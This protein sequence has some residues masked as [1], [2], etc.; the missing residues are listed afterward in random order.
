MDLC[1]EEKRG[2]GGADRVSALKK[3]SE[4][5][6]SAVDQSTRVS[7]MPH[8]PHR[9]RR[10]TA[11]RRQYQYFDN[12]NDLADTLVASHSLRST[13]L[14]SPHNTQHTL[15]RMPQCL[16]PLEIESNQIRPTK[17]I[18]KSTYYPLPDTRVSF[19]HPTYF[20]LQAYTHGE[21]IR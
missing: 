16:L 12:K 19:Q 5:A 9:R 14:R 18:L 4:K 17:C 11:A 13:H 2:E 10:R 7:M 20:L 15:L 6:R 21:G 8:S 1:T 3:G